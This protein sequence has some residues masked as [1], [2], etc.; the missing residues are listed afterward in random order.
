[1]A[2]RGWVIFLAITAFIY[3]GLSF[4]GGLLLLIQGA[5]SHVAPIIASGLFGLIY[6]AVAAVGGIL[7]MTYAGRLGSLAH[8]K[9]PAVLEKAMDGLRAIWIFTSIVLIVFLTLITVAI[10]WAIAVGASLP[11]FR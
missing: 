7:L 1:M 6:A 2:S 8:W 4:F 11:I 5:N 10:V 9:Q 3:A